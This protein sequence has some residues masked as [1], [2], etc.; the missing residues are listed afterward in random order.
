M[1]PERWQRVRSILEKALAQPSEARAG[2]LASACGDDAALRASVDALLESDETAG[3]FLDPPT[4][5]GLADWVLDDKAGEAVGTEVGPYRLTEVIASGGM[6]AVYRAVRADEHFDK[7]VAI[8]ILRRSVATYEMQ[9]RFQQERRALAQL[10]HPNV[11]RLIDGGTT[12]EG[13][14]YLVMDYVDGQPIDEYCDAHRLSVADRLRLFV[15]VCETVAYA[16]RNLIVHRDLKP[17]NILVTKDGTPKLVDFGIA[18][19][20]DGGPGGPVAMQTTT[21]SRAMTPQYASPEQIR[22]DAITTATDIYSLGVILYELLAGH[23]PYALDLRPRYEAERIICEEEPTPPSTVVDRKGDLVLRDGTRTVLTP[24]RVSE[25]RDDHVGRL[26]RRLRGDLDAIVLNSMQ[27]DPRRRYPSVDELADDIRR[28][29]EGLPVSACKQSVIYRTSKFARRHS[30]GVVTTAAVVLILG[31]GAT[32]TARSLLLQMEA[33]RTAAAQAIRARTEA[34]KASTLNDF[35]QEIVALVGPGS[36]SRD[37]TVREILDQIG[38]RVDTELADQ[39]DVE[40]AVRHTLGDAYIGLG[41]YRSAAPHLRRALALRQSRLGHEHP[42]TL[43]TADLLGDMLR[44]QGMFDEA[45]PILRDAFET[46][47]RV[48][49]EEHEKTLTAMNSLGLLLY[50]MDR[51]DEAEALYVKTM[52]VHHRLGQDDHCNM[53]QTMANQ[54]LLLRARR[55]LNEAE[56][57]IRDTLE[58][59]RRVL[60]EEHP[61]TLLAMNTLALLLCEQGKRV[62]GEAQHQRAL[63]TARRALGERHPIVALMLDNLGL[64]Y[65]DLGDLEKAE[66]CHFQALEIRRET[67]GMEH[68]QTLGSILNLTRVLRARG[69]LELAQQYLYDAINALRESCGD[70]CPRVLGLKRQLGEVFEARGDYPE[71]ERTARELLG[72]RGTMLANSDPV[73]VRGLILLGMCLGEQGRFAEAEPYLREALEMRRKLLPEGHSLIAVVASALGDCLTEL[74]RFEEAEQLLLYSYPV[75]KSAFGNWD[76]NYQYDWHFAAAGHEFS[77]YQEPDNVVRLDPDPVV[78]GQSVCITYR[79]NGR[80]L[81][82]A[83]Q[84]YLHYGFHGWQ[85]AITPDPPMTWNKEA[86]VWQVLVSVPPGVRMM[87]IC[88]TDAGGTD[89]PS[90]VRAIERLIA[91]YRAWGRPD[92][93]E[94]YRGLLPAEPTT[95][96]ADSPDG[97]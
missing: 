3:E 25:L 81:A 26:R 16:H 12:V 57:L 15:R 83:E 29:L 69:E 61:S 47:R 90:T 55:K 4:T 33:E 19:L 41:L 9:R 5:M 73:A 94:E 50:H 63:D 66:Q 78:P 42:D 35:V 31:A 30:L 51:L 96:P 71:C 37:V 7:Q 60:G 17:S 39:P 86:G 13:L 18:K 14:P 70:N 59:Q 92:K 76:N 32:V 97:G 95:P 36:E 64:L 77:K 43:E 34:R 1:K 46:R 87:D 93:V 88:F 20:L 6:G 56:L 53:L 52:E 10:D 40:S 84:V 74:G 21:A 62:E 28:H 8:K 27:K 72:A 75:L 82:D 58:G 22:G 80:P 65:Q 44:A 48:L 2:Y 85:T 68:N 67:L 38:H 49:G 11:I 23:R 24:H 54:A 89:N 79:P 45:E 91:L